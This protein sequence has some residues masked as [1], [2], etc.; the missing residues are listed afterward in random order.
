MNHHFSD[1]LI[2]SIVRVGSPIRKHMVFNGLIKLALAV[3]IFLPF[4]NAAEAK[5][6]RCTLKWNSTETENG[7]AKFGLLGKEEL[8]P[9]KGTQVKIVGPT[10]N[11][12]FH[13]SIIQTYGSK[14][15]NYFLYQIKCDA[16]L[17]CT[18]NRKKWSH[19]VGTEE[20]FTFTPGT[21]SLAKIGDRE[22]FEIEPSANGFNYQ[23]IEYFAE[24]EA[25]GMNLSCH[26]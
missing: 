3:F 14:N 9:F 12:T 25:H 16:A 21:K 17:N 2:F 20:V 11:K 10:S 4:A 19:G 15:K 22:I 13:W 6:Y 23:F 7:E 26:E 8:S 18:G 24:G 5:S 1:A